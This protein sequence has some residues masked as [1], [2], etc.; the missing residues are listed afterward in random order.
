MA[1]VFVSHAG[2]DLELARKVHQWLI[3]DGHK[4][5]LAHDLHDGITVGEDWKQ[6]LDDELHHR[7][8]AVVCM[9]TSAY[10]AS[11]W[12]A[13]EVSTARVLRKR[14]LPVQ[15]ERGVVHQLLESVQHIDLTGDQDTVPVSLIKALRRVDAARYSRRLAQYGGISAVIAAV[16]VI[17]LNLL[18]AP[19][20]PPNALAAP[21]TVAAPGA[22]STIGTAPAPSAASNFRPATSPRP[23][24]PGTR[25]GQST[26]STKTVTPP[27]TDNPHRYYPPFQLVK[28]WTIDYQYAQYQGRG[29]AADGTPPYPNQ[30]YGL[31]FIPDPL[32]HAYQ[33]TDPCSQGRWL[34]SFGN[35]LPGLL[36]ASVAVSADALLVTATNF[37]NPEG[38]PAAYAQHFQGWA[39]NDNTRPVRFTGT[40]TDVDGNT[41]TFTLAPQ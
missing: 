2:K 9:V 37:G 40:W 22:D 14:L 35:T 19:H 28:N 39:A 10:L 21:P 24:A 7:A 18:P 23:I 1:R 26:P 36:L 16:V 27:K 12:C 3:D 17:V 13:F 31:Q 30:E 32:C 33:A 41:G 5:F 6:R 11:P 38:S 8:D 29:I 15:A 4:V 34:D 25:S 20:S